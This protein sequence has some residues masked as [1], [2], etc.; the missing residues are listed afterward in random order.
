LNTAT[1][2]EYPKCF[3]NTERISWNNCK[4]CSCNPEKLSC[5]AKEFPWNTD[6]ACRIEGGWLCLNTK[7]PRLTRNFHG[8]Q[9]NLIGKLVCGIVELRLPKDV[10]GQLWTT[11]QVCPTNTKYVIGIK[12]KHSNVHTSTQTHLNQQFRKLLKTFHEY[13]IIR[14]FQNDFKRL[15]EHCRRKSMRPLIQRHPFSWNSAP[16]GRLLILNNNAVYDVGVEHLLLQ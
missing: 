12:M 7:T 1:V 3:W 14:E 6:L 9:R 4:K 2:T 10:L 5:G 8:V 13:S 16:R 15:P 11:L